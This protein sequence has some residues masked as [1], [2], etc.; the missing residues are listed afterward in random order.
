MKKII[1]FFLLSVFSITQ[2]SLTIDDSDKSSFIKTDDC[3]LSYQPKLDHLLP[4][5][6]IKRYYTI[7][8]SE[9]KLSYQPSKNGNYDRDSY[10][11]RWPSDRKMKGFDFYQSNEIGLKW[12]KIIDFYKEKEPPLITFNHLYRNPSEADKE[13]AFQEAD[14]ELVKRGVPQKDVQNTVKIAK[15]LAS[16]TRYL[17]IEGVGDAAAWEYSSNYLIV[18][19]GKVTFR[20][21]VNVSANTDENIAIA[22][23]LAL[24]ILKKCK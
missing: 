21:I 13:K 20:V 9:A 5:A 2:S 8:I 7:N 23:R 6:T 17:R 22:Q 10:S 14:K 11:Y 12:V 24:E 3:L 16:T 15:N 18:L 19:S 1:L 4:L